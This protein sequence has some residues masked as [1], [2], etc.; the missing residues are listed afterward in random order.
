MIHTRMLCY[1]FRRAGSGALLGARKHVCIEAFASRAM[2]DTATS[3]I[4]FQLQE[5]LLKRLRYMLWLQLK[6]KT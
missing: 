4:A 2:L 6:K 1:V 3:S 5:K